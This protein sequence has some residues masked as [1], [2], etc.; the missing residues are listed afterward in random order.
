MDSNQKLNSLCVLISSI[1]VI[2]AITSGCQSDQEK[3]ETAVNEH[4]TPKCENYS[5]SGITILDTLSME[6]LKARIDTI[7]AWL[8]YLDTNFQNVQTGM[9]ESEERL[10]EQQAN[11]EK[12]QGAL[13]AT[14][15]EQ[16]LRTQ[17]EIEKWKLLK[18]DFDT[19]I[20][21]YK[22]GLELDSTYLDYA[23]DNNFETG[24]Y[25]VKN[26]YFCDT[27]DM[28]AKVF[29]TQDYKILSESDVLLNF[30]LKTE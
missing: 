6:K 23:L 22:K 4:F 18:S 5:S 8:H 29:L 16:T 14:L 25:L 1:L 13:K 11:L 27:A 21:N 7:H 17:M 12:Y 9:A 3:L 2:M 28:T 19:Q 20:A 30:M 15:E 26:Q 24:Y 10:K